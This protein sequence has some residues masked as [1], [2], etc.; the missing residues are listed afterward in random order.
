MR[1]MGFRT[2][3]RGCAASPRVAG[4]IPKRQSLQ[5]HL[6]KSMLE[7]ANSSADS[8]VDSYQTGAFKSPIPTIDQSNSTSERYKRLIVQIGM[9]YR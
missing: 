9:G 8:F 1:H 4:P 6:Y 3:C 5:D 7:S 2:A